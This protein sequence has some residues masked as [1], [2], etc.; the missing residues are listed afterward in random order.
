M[1]CLLVHS[2]GEC[3]PIYSEKGKVDVQEFVGCSSFPVS[4]Y[5]GLSLL[6]CVVIF[7]VDVHLEIMS[8]VLGNS[9]TLYC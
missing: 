7:C 6:L 8:D 5:Y 9:L 2:S 3:P 4:T 1:K